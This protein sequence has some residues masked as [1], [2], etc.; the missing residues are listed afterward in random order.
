MSKTFITSDT[1]FG[2]G[3][4]LKFLRK[5][6]TPVRHFSSVEE[7]DETLIENWNKVVGKHDRVYHLGDI[8]IKR[9]NLI[10]LERLNGR[11][12]LI[13][14][15]HD[16]F[17]LKDYLPYFDDIRG[18]KMMPKHALCFSHIPI[19]QRS[20]ENRFQFN[21]HGHLHEK[22]YNDPRYIN[23][24]VEQTNYTPVEFDQLL[25]IIE[26]RKVMIERGEFLE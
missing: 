22:I 20:L 19:H 13:R 5:D 23:L 3:N 7:M 17:K 16:I 21:C 1:H 9:K 6:G 18:Y 26:E 24:C 12:V 11:K 14:G 15:N 10:T 4:I 2:H 8:A 25:E